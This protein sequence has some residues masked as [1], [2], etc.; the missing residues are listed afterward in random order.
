MDKC[1]RHAKKIGKIL[2]FFGMMI[3]FLTVTPFFFVQMLVDA[4]RLGEHPNP[5]AIK[6]DNRI[7]RA[8]IAYLMYHG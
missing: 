8:T 1:K 4:L 6:S 3:V 2:S 7:H 5:S